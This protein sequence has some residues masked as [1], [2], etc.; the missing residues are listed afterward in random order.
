MVIVVVLEF[1][2]MITSP[3]LAL[4]L[5]MMLVVLVLSLVTIAVLLELS[6]PVIVV[7]LALSLL[8]IAVLLVLSLATL[9]SRSVWI[10]PRR[11][12]LAST[13]RPV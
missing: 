3:L 5:A 13:V 12:K 10:C 4:E 8:I 11:L 2:L 1:A 7:V 9:F 6:L